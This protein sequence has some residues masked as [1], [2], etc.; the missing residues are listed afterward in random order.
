MAAVTNKGFLIGLLIM[1]AI[2][3]RPLRGDPRLMTRHVPPVRGEVAMVDPTGPGCAGAARGARTRCD[4]R[5]GERDSARARGGSAPEACAMRRTSTPAMERASA[6][7]RDCRFVER[8]AT[9]RSA[10]EKAWLT[11]PT[12]RRTAPAGARGH[13]ARRRRARGGT[14][15]RHL[16]PV[17][18]AEHRRPRRDA[19]CTTACARPRRR[20]LRRTALDRARSRGGDARA[21]RGVDD[22]GRR[23]RAPDATSRSI[24][25]AVRAS[26]GCWSSA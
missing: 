10:A 24:A 25:P 8:P 9:G 7:R 17:R 11:A 18:A 1:P 13:P 19:S 12:R 6:R 5:P 14:P 15:I 2:F 21:A 26:S 16:R 22:R 20:P 3:A 23:R 4:S